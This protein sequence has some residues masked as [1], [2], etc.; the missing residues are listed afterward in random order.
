MTEAARTIETLPREMIESIRQDA[1]HF[2]VYVR[3]RG[4]EYLV[5]GRVGSLEISDGLVR[6]SVKGTRTYRTGWRWTDGSADPNCTCPVAPLCK[7][8]YALA[9]A[10]VAAHAEATGRPVP[11]LETGSDV[12]DEHQRAGAAVHYDPDIEA[13]RAADPWNRAYTF[14]R[15]VAGSHGRGIYLNPYEFREILEDPDPDLMCWRLAQEIP[16]R[17]NGWVPRG[18]LPFRD[19]PDL[20]ERAAGRSRREMEEGLARWAIRHATTPS[21]SLRVLLGL[22]RDERGT[23][24]VTMEARVTS[25]RLQ[26]EPRTAMQLVQLGNELRRDAT[27][28]SPPH[29]R[30]LRALTGGFL[31]SARSSNDRRFELVTG[32]VNRLLDNFADSALATWGDHLDPELAARAGIT[33]GKRLDLEDTA[34]D[35]L[36]A[37]LNDAG[38]M[39]IALAA[40]W[41]DGRQLPLDTVVFLA[42]D[43]DLHPS[44]VLADGVFW[45]VGEEPPHDLLQRF[46]ATGSLPVPETGREQF[47][48]ILSASFASVAEAL[49]PHTRRH[50]AHPVAALD[51][52]DDD[53]LEV[54]LFAHSS[55]KE[56]RPG[57]PIGAEPVFEFTR[58]SRWARLL[59][60]SG[61]STEELETF[62]PDRPAAAE[63][64][65]ATD[66]EAAAVPVDASD[67]APGGAGDVPAEIWL[68]AP[69]PA[70][71]DPARDWLQSFAQ[72]G[73]DGRGGPPE[74]SSDEARKS[75]WLRINARNLETFAE[76]WESRPTGVAYLGNRRMRELLG[77]ARNVRPRV[78]VTA[79]GVDWFAV[80]AE[81]ESEGMRLTDADLAKLRGARTRFVKLQSGWVRRDVADHFDQ[82]A[83]SLADLGIEVGGGE[84]RVTLWQLAQARPDS[85]MALEDFGADSA[86]AQE[87]ERLREKVRTFEGLPRTELPQGLVAELRPY[88]H[89]GLD[90]LSFVTG[91]G[92][93]AVLADDMGLGKTVQ[94]LAW[95]LQLR[96]RE[97]GL[98]PALVVCPASVVH[99]WV[100]EAERFTPGLRVLTLTSG[101]ERHE[102]RGEIPNHDLIVTNYALLR[103]DL[104]QWIKVP[105]SAA[106]LDEAQN[107]KNPDAA[108]SKAVLRLDARHRLALTGT[109]LENRALDLWSIMEFVNPGYL[110][111]RAKFVARY[112][113]PDTP[114][115]LRALLAAR[116]RPVVLRRLKRQ[117]ARDLPDRIEERRDC[118]LT[119]G[120]RQLYLAELANSRKLVERISTNGDGVRRHKIEILAALT[121]LRQVCCHPALAGGKL[122]LGSGKFDALFEL[123]EPLLA[124]GHKVLVFSQFVECLKLLAQDMT[125]RGVRHHMLT[126]AT[127]RREA[128]VGAFE[129]DPEPCVFLIS[130]KAGGTGLNLTAASYVVLFDPWWNPAVEAQAIDRTHRIGQTRTVI[131]YRMLAEGTIEEKI[132]ELQQRKAALVRDVIGEDGFARTLTGADLDYLLRDA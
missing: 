1:G 64:A 3:N 24:C 106:I 117:V 18:L 69:D 61:A 67:T 13:L 63:G 91:I 14:G 129:S 42:A 80:S 49:S 96:E 11:E 128:V 33:P 44:L 21:R 53:W 116:L 119:V 60:P 118:Q 47:L 87:L 112:D 43:D 57:M 28:L 101:E 107:I 73:A 20:A 75:W 31:P 56:W 58:E 12:P 88:Q 120:Q 65:P 127:T 50:R 115:H 121:R 131:A 34:L 51:L 74:L 81:W 37:C 36:P 25:G 90:F 132:W 48:E 97:P 41:P 46:A 92:R 54:R 102:L 83:A 103:R 32:S 113:R 125:R 22:G 6:A 79:S 38:G 19:R 16:Q 39:R 122:E 114:P 26:D 109:P 98:G 111:N 5:W 124:E 4:R 78:N 23:A 76:A 89:E 7:H 100:R 72:G 86:A 35:I 55:D 94:A 104:E 8:A 15:V 17:A 108:I 123:L 95:L 30:L 40:R 10:V 45:R 9:L 110:G 82:D 59:G 126:G 93:G 105:L 85:L 99:N 29:A 66:D 77:G 84:Q 71:V 27:L 130:L 70:Q 68:D 62:A 52:H 2:P